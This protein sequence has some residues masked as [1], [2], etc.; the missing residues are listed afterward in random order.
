MVLVPEGAFTMG[1]ATTCT[2]DDVEAMPE[3]EARTGRYFIDVDEVTNARYAKFLAAIASDGHKTCPKDEPANKDHAPLD[4]KTALYEDA[5]VG[6][7]P[8]GDYPVCGVDWYDA[9]AYAAWA[10]KRLPTEPEWEKAARGTDGRPYPWGFHT[11]LSVG[12][13]G[14]ASRD[15]T[16]VIRANWADDADGYDFTSPVGKFPQ[17]RS[18]YGCEDMGGNVWEWTESNFSLYPGAFDNLAA[19][20]TPE[21]CAGLRIFRGGSYK[22]STMDIQTTHRHWVEPEKRMEDCGFRCVVSAP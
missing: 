12:R 16:G 18:F 15:D 9:R 13:T 2:T 20:Y 3:H 1:V 6:R 19:K 5:K 11:P 4:W 8:G 10:G 14:I 7:S 17:G 21:V 22:F